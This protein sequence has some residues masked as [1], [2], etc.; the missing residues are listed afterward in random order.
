MLY[1]Q[2][3]LL[4]ES[5]DGAFVASITP[6]PNAFRNETPGTEVNFLVNMSATPASATGS[7][8]V[9]LSFQGHKV[10]N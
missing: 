7:G 9:I 2:A 4:I 3:A 5:D 8:E 10:R 1:A 6:A